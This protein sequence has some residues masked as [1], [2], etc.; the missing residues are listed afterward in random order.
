MGVV[1]TASQERAGRFRVRSVI[2]QRSNAQVSPRS[3]RS[4]ERADARGR[5]APSPACFLPGP[6]SAVLTGLSGSRHLYQSILNCHL[7][8]D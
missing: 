4:G 1:R 3:A 5:G 8:G 2:T 6:A 7:T